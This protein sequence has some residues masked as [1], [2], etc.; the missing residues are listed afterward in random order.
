MKLLIISPPFGA[1]GQQSKGL[2]IA[3]PVLEYLA[4]LTAQLRPEIEVALT[5]ANTEAF[6][7]HAVDADLVA[8][9]V[10]T[11]QAPWAYR[12]ADVLRARGVPVVM[13]G[14][15]VTALPEEAAAHA[16]AVVLGEA[17]SIWARVLDDFLDTRPRAFYEG[18]QIPLEGLPLPR[19]GLLSAR[20]RFGSFFTSRGCPFSC[21]FCS[22][23]TVFGAKARV[24]PIDE[25]VAEVAASPYRMFWN[26][27]DNVW[28]V[29]VARSIDLF[30]EM[31]AQVRGKWWFGAGDLATV[32]TRRGDELLKAARRAGMTAAMV[33]YESTSLP[34]LEEYRA[35]S[36]QGRDRQDAIRRIKAA[37][38]DVMLFIMVGGRQDH[39]RQFDEVLE[40][41]DRLGVAAHPVMTTPFPGTALREIYEPYLL[42]GMGW[43]LH[44]GNHALFEHPDPDMAPADREGALIQL[45]AELFTL[46]RILRRVAKVGAKGFPMAQVT[47]FMVQ[48]PQGRSF[49][50]FARGYAAR[51]EEPGSAVS[52]ASGPGGPA[53]QETRR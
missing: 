28:G 24:R 42:E 16:D 46:P 38:I 39:R 2:P 41:S 3:P 40:L 29:D 20:Y 25:V 32:Q 6:D 7:P 18:A 17:E 21:A 37:G 49:R 11:P 8:F 4:G 5:D 12:T 50:Q 13:G 15:H 19:H 35:V 47:S 26:I 30:R 23:H 36:K 44:D 9:T 45:R 52:A 10:L 43:D 51:A 31:A 48:Y 33:G 22:V 53:T 34:T 14:I 1:G 27:D